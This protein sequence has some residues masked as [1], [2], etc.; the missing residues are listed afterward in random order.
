L[1]ELYVKYNECKHNVMFCKYMENIRTPFNCPK[2]RKASTS[3][4]FNTFGQ[5]FLEYVKHEEKH[6]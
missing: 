6:I 3:V 4:V 2:C 5:S 1:Y